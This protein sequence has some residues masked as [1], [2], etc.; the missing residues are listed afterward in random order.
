MRRQFI[1]LF[2]LIC[3][4]ASSTGYAHSG[5]TDAKGGHYD[6]STGQYHYHHGY[7]AHQHPNGVCPY[8]NKNSTNK[9]ATIKPA[10]TKSAADMLSI[11]GS[12]TDK[13]I[14]SA[15]TKTSSATATPKIRQAVTMAPGSSNKSTPRPTATPTPT[16]RP[17]A[18]KKAATQKPTASTA[19][20]YVADDMSHIWNYTILGGVAF[21][22]LCV[23][24]HASRSRKRERETFSTYHNLEDEIAKL[25]ESKKATEKELQLAYAEISNLERNLND[26]NHQIDQLRQKNDSDLHMRKIAAVKEEAEQKLRQANAKI[27]DLMQKL[28]ESQQHI[29]KLTADLKKAQKDALPPQLMYVPPVPNPYPEVGDLPIFYSTHYPT[30]WA[31]IQRYALN[32]SAYI[33]YYHFIWGNLQINHGDGLVHGKLTDEQRA[34]INYPVPGSDIFIG[35]NDSIHYHNTPNC[36]T[37]LGSHHVAY[38][39]SNAFRYIPCSKCVK[40]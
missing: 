14:N 17:T 29:D 9:I 11:V 23:A 16:P 34:R 38:S 10:S 15:N 33:H 5:G 13:A 12:L 18:T 19:P 7:S 27:S 28:R 37:L 24:V 1:L 40:E 30:T 35:T 4:L 26:T 2:F 32:K 39:R 22:S 25:L 8:E 31:Y 6:H 20:L 21:I 3:A 36:Y